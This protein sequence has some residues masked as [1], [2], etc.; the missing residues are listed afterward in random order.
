MQGNLLKGIRKALLRV[1][2]PFKKL[3]RWDRGFI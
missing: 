1:K 2:N 3:K